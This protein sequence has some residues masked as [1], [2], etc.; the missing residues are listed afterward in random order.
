MKKIVVFA[1]TCSLAGFVTSP[2]YADPSITSVSGRWTHKLTVN[3]NGS[4]FGVKNSAAPLMWDDA[5]SATVGTAPSGT[6]NAQ[7][8][9]GYS[10]WLPTATRDRETITE[11]YQIKYRNVNYA[12]VF[13]SVAG[14]HSNSTKYIAGGHEETP[15]WMAGRD[16]ALTV[17]TP[18][19]FS[20]R[21]FVHFY[22]KL[23]PEWPV[24]CGTGRNHK[25]T[26][27]QAG[28]QIYSN[29]PYDN[30]YHY[31]DFGDIHP[32]FG[33]DYV[34]IKTMPNGITGGGSSN[35]SDTSPP[36]IYQQ[37]NQPVVPNPINEWIRISQVIE[38][39]VGNA[40]FLINNQIMWGGS[41]NPYW[42]TDSGSN[43]LGFAGI[44]SFGIG[45][46]YRY[47]FSRPTNNNAFR[48]FD[49]VYIDSTLSRVML[50]NNATYTSARICDPQ[51]P[52]AWGDASITVTVNQ[53]SL[54]SGTAY[55]FIFD[56]NG[57]ANAQGYLISLVTESDQAL[58]PPTGLRID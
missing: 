52:S 46:F 11:P 36:W 32:C 6:A 49:D 43:D 4:G 9:V 18:S 31:W 2:G 24:P 27:I 54:P 39:D 42:F 56:A 47:D 55:L 13:A 53:G 34:T 25:I 8:Q 22:Y 58:S 30:Q 5:E 48:F 37:D 15:A 21:W 51:V 1:L 35:V 38:N 40:Y 28:T 7:S 12:P 45:G 23:N 16:V 57:V 26:C 19:D 50:C 20:N 10:H 17:A 3:I 14:P 44:R 29:G 41:G 33:Y